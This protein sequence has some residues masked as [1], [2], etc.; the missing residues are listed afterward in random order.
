MLSVRT[1]VGRRLLDL[2]VAGAQDIDESCGCR[3]IGLLGW[4]DIGRRAVL[5]VNRAHADLI[6]VVEISLTVSRGV[7]RD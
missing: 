6:E 3:W 1:E 2:N 4:D 7:V 5:S